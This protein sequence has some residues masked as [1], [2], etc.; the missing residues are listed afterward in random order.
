MFPTIWYSILCFSLD[1]EVRFALDAYSV[2]ESEGEIS[3]E[4][5][6]DQPLVPSFPIPVSVEVLSHDAGD[7]S[8]L[9]KLFRC[10][11]LV[12]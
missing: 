3:V 9:I 2:F 4:V 10:M 8:I 5:V 1:I 6:L 7:C 11:V 12:Q